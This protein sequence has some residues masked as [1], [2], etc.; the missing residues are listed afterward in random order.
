MS[1]VVYTIRER[2]RSGLRARLL[3]AVPVEALESVRRVTALLDDASRSLPREMPRR[4]RAIALLYID[5]LNPSRGDHAR[6]RRWRRFIVALEAF[7]DESHSLLLRALV[8]ENADLLTS[9]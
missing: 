6:E 1:A 3:G 2:R 9:E 7:A 8:R 4:A 5:A